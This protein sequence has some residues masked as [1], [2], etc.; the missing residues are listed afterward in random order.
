MWHHISALTYLTLCQWC[1]RHKEPWLFVLVWPPSHSAQTPIWGT[2]RHLSALRWT[3]WCCRLWV[4]DKMYQLTNIKTI[5]ATMKHP[6]S[7]AEKPR[8]PV[9]KCWEWKKNHLFPTDFFI[10]ST[11]YKYA[12]KKICWQY[13]HFMR[14][15]FLV[16]ISHDHKLQDITSLDFTGVMNLY[17][18][19]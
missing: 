14:H 3:L 15:I 6:N 9:F 4:K 16:S 7:D 18:F 17:F 1:S 11:V 12:I 8:K 5:W 13:L 10:H 2:W 19:H